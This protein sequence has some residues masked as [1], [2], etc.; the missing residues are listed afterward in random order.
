MATI[1]RV[2]GTDRYQWPVVLHLMFMAQMPKSDSKVMEQP[3][4]LSSRGNRNRAD[5][6]LDEH[7]EM[8]NRLL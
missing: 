6:G 7:Q 1:S 3:F 5:V 4:L 2:T 8:A